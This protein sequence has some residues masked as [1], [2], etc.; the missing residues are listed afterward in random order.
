MSIFR[1]EQDFFETFSLEANPSRTFISSSSGI[2][3]SIYLF[4]QRSSAEKEAQKLSSFEDRTYGDDSIEGFRQ[5]LA[6]SASQGATNFESSMLVYIEKVNAQSVSL[7][8]QKQMEIIRFMPS[9]RFTSDTLRKN[10]VREI[11]FPYYRTRYPT[12]QWAYTNYHTLNFFTASGIPEDSCM[13]YPAASASIKELSLT[14]SKAYFPSRSFTFDFYIN[15][16]YTTDNEVTE[17]KAG[18]I[19][20]MSSSYALS[21]VTGSDVG[22]N[23]RPNAFRLM[24]QLSASAQI[25]PSIISLTASNNTRPI[26]DFYLGHTVYDDSGDHPVGN[27]ANLI[28]LSDDNSLSLNTWHHVGVRWA[29]T[30]NDGTGS[31][32]I[33]G[34]ENG[35]FVIPSASCMAAEF[36]DPLGDPDA[37][38]IGNF[39][40]GANDTDKGVLTAEF[41]NSGSRAQFGVIDLFGGDTTID[42]PSTAIC[43]AAFTH[44][45][46]AE[47]HDLKIYNSFRTLNQLL[48]SSA[49]GS[50]T[51]SSDLIF[52]VPPFFVKE[53]RKR[54]VLQT[55]FQSYST[56]T[57]D[58]FN[59][60]LS[61]GVGGHLLNLENFVREFARKQYPRLYN[62][63]MSTLDAQTNIAKSC[64]A[65]LYATASTRKRNLTVLPCDNGKFVPGFQL[66]SS[67]SLFE[68]PPS[69]SLL[70]KY[71][72]DFGALDFSYISLTNLIPTS[73]L[74]PGLFQYPL[75]G[76]AKTEAINISADP[77]GKGVI[78]KRLYKT[79]SNGNPITSSLGGFQLNTGYP[80]A[81]GTGSIAQGI[82]NAGPEN[83]GVTAGSILTIFQRNRDNTSD[84]V[85]FFDSS[86]LFYGK[87]IKPESF[88]LQDSD[89]T[90]SGGKVTITLKDDGTGNLYRADAISPHAKWNSVGNL[91]YEEGIA[92]VKSPNLPLFGKDQ[93]K[94]DLKGVQNIHILEINIPCSAG[95][96]N[97]SSNPAFKALKPSDYA[98][99]V[100]KDFVY[101]TGLNFHDE[102]LNIIARTN[103]AQP[104]IKRDKDKYKF[105]VK[106][107][108]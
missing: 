102:N 75:S 17:F 37:L 94:I 13:I 29:G 31:F 47:V 24:L 92:V 3:G 71:T 104:L 61:F 74:Q 9:V 79:D 72:N 93:F 21:L 91:L 105:R 27:S 106:L 83:P 86:N 12:A 57:D 38:F 80:D 41:F 95:S 14:G 1:L 30:A 34:A 2:T 55:M 10:V 85:V 84:E 48:T 25:A 33:D 89:V 88:S 108:F 22:V 56:K 40:N 43:A 99:T 7:R 51:V 100:E 63:E 39:W 101:V 78:A 59:V 53:S 23:G 76:T 35:T 81:I 70:D 58:P 64:N 97:S 68:V 4:A 77:A 8:K 19:F 28:F 18:T 20:H 52:Y 6:V 90:G 15:P 98:D 16:R 42:T 49:S 62:L 36:E 96:I 67:G 103:L 5:Q 32:M 46:N 87:K 44:P 45:L 11:L 54:E 60:A 26:N 66:L 107:D 82:A 50:S 73:T 65:F 69:G